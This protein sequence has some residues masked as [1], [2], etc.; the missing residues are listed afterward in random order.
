MTPRPM[1][2]AGALVALLIACLLLWSGA[3]AVFFGPR[4]DLVGQIA[5][6]QAAVDKSRNRLDDMPALERQLTSYAD[7][8]LGSDK[9]EVDAHLRQRLNRIAE[10][11]KVAGATVGTGSRSSRQSPARRAFPRSASWD[12]LRDE[13]DL[14][15]LDGWISGEG[16]FAQVMQLVDRIE[17]EP[18]LKRI[19]YLKLDPKDNGERFGFTVRLTTLYLPGRSPAEAAPAAYDRSRFQRLASLVESNPFRLRPPRPAP[20][21]AAPEAAPSPP[22]SPPEF[23]YEQWVVTG[24]AQSQAGEEVWLRNSS[25][26]ETR[27]LRVG[28][29]IGKAVF[30]S[31]RGDSAVFRIDDRHFL[32][33]AGRNLND[34]SALNP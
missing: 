11:V 25:T 23:P 10:T 33:Q 19:D 32:V 1:M 27:I 20:P 31:L 3:E 26:G 21:P 22:P 4:R 16:S 17:A 34:R 18:W 28:Q 7:R 29:S 30:A 15:E 24:V 8:T 14:V 9:E 6:A 5:D 12:A 2:I 13:I